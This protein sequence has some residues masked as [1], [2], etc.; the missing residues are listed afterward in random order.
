[1]NVTDF[2]VHCLEGTRKHTLAQVEDLT[3]AEMMFQP[4]PDV[5]H[6]TWLLGHVVTSENGLIL[7]WCAGESV[8]PEKFLKVFFMGT[9]PD[10]DPSVYPAKEEILA[11]LAEVHTRAVE[12]VK[13]L[14]A[15]QLDERPE[16]YE[17]MPAGA[18]EL[19]WSKGACIYGH[20]LHEAGHAAQISML[21]R[22]M[23]KPY[24]V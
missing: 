19:F 20:A 12:V 15:E 18:Q 16:G 5:N 23:G 13:G 11:V 1:M 9:S 21:R 17:E 14:S 3:K 10:P 22:L 8:M 24:R 4:R 2:S 7:R 6:A